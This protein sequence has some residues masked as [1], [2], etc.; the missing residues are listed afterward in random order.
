[1]EHEP[2]IQMGSDRMLPKYAYHKPVTDKFPDKCEWQNG[3]NPDNKGGLVWYTDGFKT[4]KC[5]GAVVNG[6]GSRRGHSFS[7]GLH[8][9]VFQ[10]ERYAIK[11][12]NGEYRKGLH[13]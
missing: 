7:L 1:M 5:T 11:A 4:N 3:F 10:A 12:C 8:T 6:W 2:I 9:T 13:R